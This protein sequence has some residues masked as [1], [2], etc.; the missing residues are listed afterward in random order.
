MAERTDIAKKKRNE[1][2]FKQNREKII[3]QEY[4]NAMEGIVLKG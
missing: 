3:Y 1:R 2:T 4:D